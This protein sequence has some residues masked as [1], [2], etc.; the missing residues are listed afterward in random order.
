M[1]NSSIIKHLLSDQSSLLA[2]TRGEAVSF[3]D[4]ARRL[5]AMDRA[6]DMNIPDHYYLLNKGKSLEGLKTVSDLLVDGIYRMAENHLEMRQNRVYIKQGKQLEW[7]NLI[8]KIPP[9][10]LVSS[11]IASKCTIDC[12]SVQSIQHFYTKYILPNT[13]NTALPDSFLPQLETHIKESNGLHDLHMHLNGTTETDVAWQ[14]F[15]MAPDL[16]LKELEEGYSNEMT[17]EQFEEEAGLLNPKQLHAKLRVARVIR[18]VFYK[19]IYYKKTTEESCFCCC[20]WKED[21]STTDK[22]KESRC[23]CKNCLYSLFIEPDI[24]PSSPYHP[25]YKLVSSSAGIDQ[26]EGLLLSIEALM[27]VLLFN[28]LREKRHEKLAGLFHC[29]LLILGLSNRLMVQQTTQIGFRQFQKITVNELRSVSEK[30][31]RRRFY[32]LHGNDMRNMKFLEGRFSP[33]DSLSK[34][35][36]MLWNITTGWSSLIENIDSD[37]PPQLKLIAHFIKKSDRKPDKDIRHKNLRFDLW[38]RAKVLAGMMS[39]C[40]PLV[41]DVCGVDAASS[42]FDAPPEAF[43]PIY[44]MLRRSG[45]NH[46]TYHAG[47]DFYHLI[48]GLRAIYE[49]VEFTGLESGDRIGHATATGLSPQIWINNVG[50]RMLIRQGEYLDDLVFVYHFIISL[51]IKELEPRL[52]FLINLIQELAYDVYNEF[53]G[54]KVLEDAWLLRGYCPIMTQSIICNGGDDF[55]K[56]YNTLRSMAKKSSVFDDT[57]FCRIFN[58]LKSSGSLKEN[59]KIKLYLKYHSRAFRSNYDKIIE[60]ESLDILNRDDLECLQLSILK[61]LHNK[62]IVI[63]TLPTSNIRIGHHLDYST[64]HLINWLNWEEEGYSIP[65]IVVGTDDAGIF[66]TNIYNEF[67]NIYYILTKHHN[68]SHF[69]AIS[70]LK[71]FEENAKIYKFQ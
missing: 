14:D 51:K 63:E 64:H 3:K 32:Q 41:K 55:V 19:Y 25:F 18:E 44:R 47:E 70:T 59:D 37:N 4:I 15:L 2:Y 53:Y 52:P 8:T 56:N 57:E 49:T 1:P 17:R 6:E 13:K 21:K 61:Y 16:I 68:Y 29:Y 40:S 36:E 39:S 71:R 30:S 66:A 45:F 38:N 48:G 9:L 62:E 31:Y 20:N 23:I 67:A 42:E 28:Y 65:P 12:K 58:K 22:M 33:R 34:A 54:L 60:I 27:Y 10:V 46:F 24:C 7:Q 35:E 43:A 69:K 5:F 50:E 26:N 11:F